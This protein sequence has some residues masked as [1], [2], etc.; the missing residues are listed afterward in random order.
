MSEGV[1]SCHFLKNT[2][3][4]DLDKELLKRGK[5]LVRSEPN[6]NFVLTDCHWTNGDQLV[7]TSRDPRIEFFCP[8]VLDSSQSRKVKVSINAERDSLLQLYFAKN[9]NDFTADKSKTVKVSKGQND[10]VASIPSDVT[11]IRLDPCDYA[12]PVGLKF[13]IRACS[14]SQVASILNKD[15]HET[16]TA[17]VF[18]DDAALLTSFSSAESNTYDQL[19]NC[20][21]EGKSGNLI[22]TNDDPQIHFSAGGI[23]DN[24][25]LR[26]VAEVDEPSYVQLFYKQGFEDFSEKQSIHARLCKGKNELFLAL[27]RHFTQFRLDPCALKG[28]C[29][30]SFQIAAIPDSD[31]QI[32]QKEPSK[33]KADKTY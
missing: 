6:D 5:T 16:G 1:L 26:F 18:S 25:V 22:C 9:N 20:H 23:H 33:V 21:V 12:G 7:S 29:Q 32:A 10:F 24:R 4:S 2:L 11:R 15:K 31:V 27:P 8:T 3:E 14:N 30:V 19:R 28:A 13:E 17:S